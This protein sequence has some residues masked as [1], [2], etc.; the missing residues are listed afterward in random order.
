MAA[1]NCSTNTGRCVFYL[2]SCLVVSLSSSLHISN[3]LFSLLLLLHH[4]ASVVRSSG[5]LPSFLFCQVHVLETPFLRENS[6]AG[7]QHSFFTSSSP[8]LHFFFSHSTSQLSQILI[9]GYLVH[10][11]VESLSLPSLLRLA[12]SKEV[13]Q[14]ALI[15][16]SASHQTYTDT[17]LMY[18]PLFLHFWFL[19]CFRTTSTIQLL[20]SL[21]HSSEQTDPFLYCCQNV[22]PVS[23]LVSCSSRQCVFHPSDVDWC[24]CSYSSLQSR[25]A[26][27]P[28]YCCFGTCNHLSSGEG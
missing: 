28:S 1:V 20:K 5:L 23:K 24:L 7:Y 12:L 17:I 19:S 9:K 14:R 10:S 15:Q 22:I 21:T 13:S 26:G 4:R 6:A 27:A 3:N 25:L 2:S 8:F 18:A 11:S 16:S